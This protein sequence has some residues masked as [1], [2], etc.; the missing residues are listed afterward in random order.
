MPVDLA[1]VALVE[2]LE[3]DS[4]FDTLLAV[5][6]K[7]TTSC[8]I[9]CSQDVVKCLEDSEDNDDEDLA[10]AVFDIKLD[11]EAED[12]EAILARKKQ[13]AYSASDDGRQIKRQKLEMS[14]PSW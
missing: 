7:T 11:K 5:L 13:L 12:L 6:R 8:N 14:E 2:E 4:G 1:K 3:R 10:P 9:I